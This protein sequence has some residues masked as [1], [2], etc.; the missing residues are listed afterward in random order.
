VSATHAG[1][2]SQAHAFDF[3]WGDWRTDIFSHRT[4][5]HGRVRV[6]KLWGGQADLEETEIHGSRGSLAAL[7]LRLY[8]PTARQWYLYRA[9]RADGVLDGPLIGDFK[10]GRGVFYD[11]D[12][13]AGHTVFVRNVYFDIAADS[14]RFERALSD[15]GGRSWRTDFTARLTRIAR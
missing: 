5:T 4:E 10:G 8:D 1:T 2:D 12:T 9:S 13:I 15:D 3:A 14:Y 6:R 7:T 11:E